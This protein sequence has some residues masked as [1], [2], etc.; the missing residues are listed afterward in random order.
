M[1]KRLFLFMLLLVGTGVALAQDVTFETNVPSIAVKGKEF[2]V[3]YTLKNGEGS[4]PR[5]ASKIKG[6]DIVSGPSVSQSSNISIIEGKKTTDSTVT[7]TFVLA[8]DEVGTYS[9]PGACVSID[10][11]IYKSKPAI[12]KILANER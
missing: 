2:K 4:T 12:I 7:Y 5:F 6:I 8:A 3:T 11:K 10:G 9:I 1:Q